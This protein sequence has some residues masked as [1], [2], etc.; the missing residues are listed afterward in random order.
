MS[1]YRRHHA[2]NPAV[3]FIEV[4]VAG[5]K[6]FTDRAKPRYAPRD[7]RQP[8]QPRTTPPS[9]RQRVIDLL[10]D[11]DRRTRD[12]KS[13]LRPDAALLKAWRAGKPLFTAS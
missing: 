4:P 11:L 10:R 12:A 3:I 13:M 2:M 1:D 9:K 8:W 7:Q 5:S 6:K